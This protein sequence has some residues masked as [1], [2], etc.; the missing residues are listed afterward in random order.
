MRAGGSEI[1][2]A[3]DDVT[4]ALNVQYQNVPAMGR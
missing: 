3:A 1:A 2:Q 4:H